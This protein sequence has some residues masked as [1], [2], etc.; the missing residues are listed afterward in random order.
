[1]RAGILRHG[2]ISWFQVLVFFDQSTNLSIK[3]LLTC[4]SNPLCIRRGRSTEYTKCIERRIYIKV[5]IH[6]SI[7]TTNPHIDSPVYYKRWKNRSPGK[8]N[9][10][11]SA[12]P[13]HVERK[14]TIYFFAKAIVIGG[15]LFVFRML[16]NLFR[17]SPTMVRLLRESRQEHIPKLLS[18]GAAPKTTRA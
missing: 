4:P 1:M 18:L 2:S 9:F 8:G 17:N 16:Y 6:V 13:F 11:T 14:C 5:S 10:Q 15:Y 7:Y 12:N 3:I